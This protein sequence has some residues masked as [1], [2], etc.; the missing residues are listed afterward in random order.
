MMID[1]ISKKDLVPILRKSIEE[2]YVNIHGDPST[3]NTTK[4][5][6]ELCLLRNL[7]DLP[8]YFYEKVEEN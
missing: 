3:V 2:A 6:I 5:N 8:V 1:C 4:N 7:N